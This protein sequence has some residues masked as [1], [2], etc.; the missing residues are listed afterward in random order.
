MSYT[1]HVKEWHV[2]HQLQFGYPFY[3][4]YGHYILTMAYAIIMNLSVFPFILFYLLIA[5]SREEVSYLMDRFNNL[6]RKE[7]GKLHRPEFRDELNRFFNITDD[8]LMD[9]GLSTWLSLLG[10]FAHLCL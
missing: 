4:Y 1:V 6:C 10:C 2:V 5:V 7:E 8:I 9:R 3:R